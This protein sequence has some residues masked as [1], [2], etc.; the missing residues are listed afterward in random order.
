VNCATEQ[1]ILRMLPADKGQ[2]KRWATRPAWGGEFT[3]IATTSSR[4]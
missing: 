2:S 1:F 4:R 3:T